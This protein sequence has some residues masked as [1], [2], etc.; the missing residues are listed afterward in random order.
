MSSPATA[1]WT[2]HIKK[3]EEMDPV[4]RRRD[5]MARKLQGFFKQRLAAKLRAESKLF[6]M[7][8]RVRGH[9]KIANHWDFD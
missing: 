2:L 6:G 1:K 5:Q 8:S 3:E 9:E 4:E 7:L